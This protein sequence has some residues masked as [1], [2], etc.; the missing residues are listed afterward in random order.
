MV[1]I[2]NI[3][4]TFKMILSWQKIIFIS[5]FFRKHNKKQFNANFKKYLDNNKDKK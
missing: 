1:Y 4:F 3:Q 2:A 5:T